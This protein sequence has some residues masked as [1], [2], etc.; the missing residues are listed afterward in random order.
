MDSSEECAMSTTYAGEICRKGIEQLAV[1]SATI[2]QE[3]EGGIP[4]SSEI[5]SRS[6]TVMANQSPKQTTYHL[7]LVVPLIS[8]S[9]KT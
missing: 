8:F 1:P 5:T 9:C 2:S 4:T 7:K 6:F 3:E